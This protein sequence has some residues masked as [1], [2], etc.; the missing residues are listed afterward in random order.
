MD[1]LKEGVVSGD[2]SAFKDMENRVANSRNVAPSQVS[3][4]VVNL[5]GTGF[6][7][8]GAAPLNL[9]VNNGLVAPEGEAFAWVAMAC[10]RGLYRIFPARRLSK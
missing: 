8:D 5:D 2:A 9:N 3:R 10:A 7:D 4:P 1:V 6:G